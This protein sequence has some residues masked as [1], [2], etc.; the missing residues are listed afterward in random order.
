MNITQQANKLLF[1]FSIFDPIKLLLVIVDIISTNCRIV[2]CNVGGDHM[3]YIFCPSW[4]LLLLLYVC[5]WLSLLVQRCALINIVWY[6][7]R[8]TMCGGDGGARGHSVR[9]YTHFMT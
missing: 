3:K 1:F 4:Q 9:S 5:V 8:R 7:C 2:F 6:G